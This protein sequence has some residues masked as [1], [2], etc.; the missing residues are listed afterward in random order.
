MREWGR[1]TVTTRV[2][3]NLHRDTIKTLGEMEAAV[4][5]AR[6]Y[7]LPNDSVFSYDPMTGELFF[8]WT[9]EHNYDTKEDG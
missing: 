8:E 6:E 5:R 9:R 4:N 2:Y 7:E 1:T 3:L